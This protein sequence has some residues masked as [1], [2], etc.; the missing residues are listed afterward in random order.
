M[1]LD[2][3]SLE[4]SGYIKEEPVPSHTAFGED[5]LEIILLVCRLSGMVDELPVLVSKKLCPEDGALVKGRYISISGQ[6]RS[7]NETREGK[8][9]LKLRAFAKTLNAEEVRE[10]SDVNAIEL[11]GFICKTPVYRTTPLGREICDILVAVNRAYNK[12]DYIPSVL[13][14]RNARFGQDLKVGQKVKIEGRFQSREYQKCLQSG[15]IKTKT[16]YEVS[17]SMIACVI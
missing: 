3:N 17:V 16:A 4:L 2:T 6:L 10:D 8:A 11:E 12:S 9:H 13:W 14:G 15:E 7:Y 5:F 1:K